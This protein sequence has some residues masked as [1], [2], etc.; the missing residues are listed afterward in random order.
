MSGKFAK[1]NQKNLNLDLN[2]SDEKIDD[3]TISQISGITLLKTD[4]STSTLINDKSF[5]FS[6]PIGTECVNFK[7]SLVQ[8][9]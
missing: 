1:Q 5:N 3:F 7:N 9:R 2:S 8:E 6:N 4:K